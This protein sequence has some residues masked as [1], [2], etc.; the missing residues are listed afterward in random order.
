MLVYHLLK[1]III[2]IEEGYEANSW[3]HNRY[4]WDNWWSQVAGGDGGYIKYPG[5]VPARDAQFETY[6]KG[7]FDFHE[8]ECGMPFG[9]A[10]YIYYTQQQFDAYGYGSN[11]PI[12]RDVNDLANEEEIF[13]YKT[14]GFSGNVSEQVSE[15]LNFGT[16]ALGF[17]LSEAQAAGIISPNYRY[18]SGSW[19]SVYVYS[20]YEHAG[21]LTY[22][23]ANQLQG[24]DGLG[25]ASYWIFMDGG[26]HYNGYVA[27]GSK[28]YGDVNYLP[29]PGDLIIYGGN[30]SSHA[31]HVG[32]VYEVDP[33]SGTMTTLEGNTGGGYCKLKENK[34]YAS[35]AET[36]QSSAVAGSSQPV[37]GF[38]SLESF[39]ASK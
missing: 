31:S 6:V 17:T 32:M 18:F 15:M 10:Y 37:I 30:Y 16:Q 35:P 14:G 20:L 5:T 11:L 29:S 36:F 27:D 8:S 12:T 19:C 25:F 23:E 21:I 9:R 4:I 34:L 3:E 39:L 38:F 1:Y 7:V 2:G 26:K 13:T 33:A 28:S 24:V 22:E